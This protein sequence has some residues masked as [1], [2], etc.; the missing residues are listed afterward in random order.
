MQDQFFYAFFIFLIYHDVYSEYTQN[1]D[2]K[3]PERLY[4]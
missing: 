2:S 3:R 1:N 4:I